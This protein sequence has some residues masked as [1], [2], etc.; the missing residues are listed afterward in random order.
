MGSKAFGILRGPHIIFQK[1]NDFASFRGKAKIAS[2]YILISKV[3]SCICYAIG[4]CI[5]LFIGG[6]IFGGNT[7]A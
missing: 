3:H 2:Q 7:C 6:V 5:L 1:A 4:S